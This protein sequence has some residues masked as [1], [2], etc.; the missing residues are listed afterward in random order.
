MEKS[1]A[2]YFSLFQFIDNYFAA[3]TYNCA[4]HFKSKLFWE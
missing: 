3:N 4:G 2:G 1:E